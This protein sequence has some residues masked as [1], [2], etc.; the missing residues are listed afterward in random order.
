MRHNVNLR[1]RLLDKYRLEAGIVEIDWEKGCFPLLVIR[2]QT[3]GVHD[4][5]VARNQEPIPR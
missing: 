1:N 3:E 2:P 4:T 5:M